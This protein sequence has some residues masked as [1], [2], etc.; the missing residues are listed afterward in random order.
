MKILL[1]FCI[2][3]VLSCGGSGGGVSD[4]L[5]EPA[6]VFINPYPS[7]IP[8]VDTL[9][10]VHY[11]EIL[12][13][14]PKNV[15]LG[16]FHEAFGGDVLALVADEFQKGREHIRVN[17]LWKDDHI[18]ANSSLTY[19]IDVA[20]KYELICQTYKNS[21][22][23]L[24]AFTEHRESLANIE[25]VLSVVAANSPSCGQPINSTLT[26]EL[27]YESGYENEVHGL[28]D[29]PANRNSPCSYSFDGT[30]TISYSRVAPDAIS[31]K[32]AANETARR[33]CVWH[34]RL[35][36]RYTTNDPTSRTLRVMEKDSRKPTPELI[37]Q[38]LSLLGE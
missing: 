27:S 15:S 1:T 5:E 3:F 10:G 35:N 38:L 14:I 24:A 31:L 7:Q 32:R 4:V 16:F 11:P 37:G 2:A 23:Q 17:I 12:D 21:S 26:G 9:A 13:L 29:C 20:Q 33:F 22:L 18:Y 19:I 28:S 25:Y 34:P 30:D 8:C 36:L 6:L